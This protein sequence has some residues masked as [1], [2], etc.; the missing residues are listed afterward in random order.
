M[1][2]KMKELYAGSDGVYHEGKTYDMNKDKGSMFV[3]LGYAE[4]IEEEPDGEAVDIDDIDET[5]GDAGSADI[6][7]AVEGST[8]EVSKPA[9][10]GKTKKGE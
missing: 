1:K 3:Q 10:K 2:I 5:D 8:A 7:E 9:P 6:D 4:T